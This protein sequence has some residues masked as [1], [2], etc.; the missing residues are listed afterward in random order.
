M[1]WTDLFRFY[2][3]YSKIKRGL[4]GGM[5]L[6]GLIQRIGCLQKADDSSFRIQSS[7][8]V[9]HILPSEGTPDHGKGTGE[10]HGI[11]SP[12]CPLQSPRPWGLQRFSSGI[13]E[14]RSA[15]HMSCSPSKPQ[16]GTDVTH[17]PGKEHPDHSV[18]PAPKCS[19]KARKGG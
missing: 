6:G 8:S 11:F 3:P 16:A 12:R 4:L 13:C 19:Q 14:A 15:G 1:W 10:E 17:K 9:S 18:L 2:A 5:L 7:S